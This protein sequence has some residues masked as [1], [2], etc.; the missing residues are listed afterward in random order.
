MGY[1]VFLLFIIVPFD[2]TCDVFI[3]AQ[4]GL[5]KKSKKQNQYVYMCVYVC[6]YV[7]YTLFCP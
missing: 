2:T 6:M 4:A 5:V 7:L 3:N 1:L